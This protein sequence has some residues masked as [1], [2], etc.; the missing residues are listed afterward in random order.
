MHYRHKTISLLAAMTL[1]VAL[2]ACAQT[3]AQEKMLESRFAAADVNHDG[4]LT[5]TE[6]QAGMPR[7]A[8]HFDEIDSQHVG[9]ITLEQIKIFIAQHKQ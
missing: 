8:P 7:L 2:P 4:K 3:D 1:A 9:Y 5:K 6:A